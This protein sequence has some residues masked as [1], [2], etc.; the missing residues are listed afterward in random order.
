MPACREESGTWPMSPRGCE[1]VWVCSS[2]GGIFQLIRL[3]RPSVLYLGNY[4]KTG[5]GLQKDSSQSFTPYLCMC[6]KL[7]QFCPTLCNPK[8]HSL[9]V[10]SVHE[11]SWQEYWSRLPNPPPRDFPDPWTKTE[12]LM[13]P[14]LADKFF[15]TS[16]A[17]PYSAHHKS[18]W[19]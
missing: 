15:T 7:L 12:P 6:A 11:F 16:D 1:D 8:D 14:A 5:I 13:S 9:T 4:K 2:L 18:N 3:I 10:S 19:F 17:M